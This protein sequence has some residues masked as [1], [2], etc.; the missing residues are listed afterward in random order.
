MDA[1]RHVVA[2]ASRRW[3]ELRIRYLR[4]R[5]VATSAASSG[6]E[7]DAMSNG[8]DAS[9]VNPLR[10]V[11][12]LAPKRLLLLLILILVFV[13]SVLRLRQQHHDGPATPPP[14]PEGQ[15]VQTEDAPIPEGVHGVEPGNHRFVIVL[16]TE[17]SSPDLCKVI[18]SALAMGYPMPVIVN[19]NATEAHGPG[20]SHLAKVA[21]TLAYL[22]EFSNTGAYEGDRLS[23]TD[24]VLIIDPYDIWFQLPPEVLLSR[25]HEINAAA[26]NRLAQLW[27]DG[28]EMMPMRQTI[29]ASSQKR[30]YPPPEPGFDPHCEI[31]PDSPLQPDTYGPNTDSDPAVNPRGYHDVRPKFINS[32]TIMGP[33]G[34]VRRY[35]RRVLDRM[36]E[37]I[38]TYEVPIDSDQRVFAE[39]FGEQEVYRQWRRSTRFQPPEGPLPVK[40]MARE[41]EFHVGLDY[42]QTIAMT[43]AFSEEDG[44]FVTFNNGAEIEQHSQA[45]GITPNRLYGLPRDIQKAHHPLDNR[46]VNIK[47]AT[48]DWTNYSLYAD[49]F[50]TSVPVLL[51][52]NGGAKD[53]RVRWW[54][55]TW[56]FPYLRELVKAQL[57]PPAKVKALARIPVHGGGDVVYW[58]PSS[59]ASRRLPRLHTLGSAGE[60]L[61]TVQFD[62]LCRYRGEAETK[63][64]YD[65]VFRDGKGGL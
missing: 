12:L 34:D 27:G 3:E 26:N 46:L 10:R 20:G 16:P 45:L 52:H 28:F 48:Y 59:D 53:R 5:P 15:V 57:M 50:T 11:L 24:I 8:A 17:G 19:W 60:K 4:Y 44:T 40:W 14:Q 61:G 51:H 58:P 41:Y 32:G 2:D 47:A 42:H 39:V 25:F 7:R 33:V 64:W 54:D 21:G 63:H 30:C 49:F 1:V 62:A 9:R 65:E 18:T 36:D 22:D 31:L 29:V 6:K 35:F 43:T 55:R 38:A 56:F 13:T 23:D 37:M